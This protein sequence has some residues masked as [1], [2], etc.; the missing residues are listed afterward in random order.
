MLDALMD[1]VDSI[2]K[3]RLAQGSSV[4]QC[5]A[6]GRLEKGY[7]SHNPPYLGIIVE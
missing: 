6:C 2:T 1:F 5:K 7:I 3:K 4:R